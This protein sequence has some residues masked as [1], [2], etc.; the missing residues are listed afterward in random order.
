MADSL[1]SNLKLTLQTVGGNSGTWGTIAN[2]NFQRIDD[3]L[4]DKTS[5]ATTGGTTTLTETQEEVAVID[6]SGTLVSNATIAFSGRGGFWIVKNGTAGSFSLTCKVTGQTGITVGQGQ[7]SLIWCNGTDILE[8]IESIDSS[9]FATTTGAAWAAE[10]SVSDSATPDIGAAASYRVTV[11]GTTT[12]TGLGTAAAG[13]WRLVRWST[14]RTLTYNATSLIL[15]GAAN[16]SV[17]AGDFSMFRSEGSGNWREEFFTRATGQAL[18]ATDMVDF[19][20]ET[21]LATGDFIPMVDIS[22]S[23]ANDKILVTDF[24]KIINAFT[25][26]TDPA[27][28][29]DYVST[30]DASASAVKKVLLKNIKAAEAIAIAASDEITPL[31]TGTAKAT[32]HM[33]FAFTV[34]GVFASLTTAQGSGSIFTVDINDG[35]TTILSTKLTIDNGENVGG[36]SGFGSSAT[37][38]VISDSAIAASAKV[39]IDIDQV[40]VGDAAGLKV[41]LIGYRT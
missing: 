35:G 19:N 10:V 9:T 15:I 24:F 26:D 25:E 16:R 27:G 21:V 29:S 6:V 4:G 37:P 34:T 36:S 13:I 33:P 20:T 28:G 30:Y 17:V 39:T 1:T 23:N 8:A 2:D 11:A 22:A 7:S 3:K 18:T 32:F 14:S 41:W 40:G 5:V 38:A 31:T 12:I